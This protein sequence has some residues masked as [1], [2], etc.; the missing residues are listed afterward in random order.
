METHLEINV[1]LRGITFTVAEFLS[2]AC[3]SN[4]V[5]EVGSSLRVDNLIDGGAFKVDPL[6]VGI[7]EVS[8]RDRVMT[9]L[10][11]LVCEF[12]TRASEDL[13][14]LNSWFLVLANGVVNMER[15]CTVED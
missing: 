3:S 4:V 8:E 9:A 12:S 6:V 14:F 11:R 1:K 7:A 5:G 15:G 10:R 2:P 13:G